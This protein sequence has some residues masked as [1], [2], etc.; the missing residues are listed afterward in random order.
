MY[1]ITKGPEYHITGLMPPLVI[2]VFKVIQ[3]QDK[4]G[5]YVP[6]CMF[7]TGAA[8]LLRGAFVFQSGQGISLCLAPKQGLHGNSSLQLLI[9]LLENQILQFLMA[10]IVTHEQ[11]SHSQQ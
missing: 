2:D 11:D 5:T 6:L 9:L 7:Q 8:Q 4:Q 10:G 3:V 1:G